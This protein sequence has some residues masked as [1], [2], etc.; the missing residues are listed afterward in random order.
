MP[1]SL[2][3][4]KVYEVL[5]SD[6]QTYDVA[7]SFSGAQRMLVE[8]YVRACQAL[9]LSVF[10]DKDV[11]AQMWGRNF[12]YEF[13]KVYGQG[14]ARYV[15]P[16]FSREYLGGSY[17]MDEYGAAVTWSIEQRDDV[18]I[19][20]I[21]IGDVRVPEELLNS[22]TAFLRAEEWTAAELAKITAERVR[23]SSA[24]ASL[25]SPAATSPGVLLPKIAPGGYSSYETLENALSLVAKRFQ[26][27][28][29]LLARYGYT[30][31]VRTPDSAVDVRVEAQGKPV[32][33]VKVWL[34]DSFGQDR[35]AVGLG[36]PSYRG[37]AMNGW[38][39]AE[40]D[41]EHDEARLRFA[42]GLQGMGAPLLTAD[43]FFE[44][45]WRKIVVR[46][47]QMH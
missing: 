1:R 40:W 22:S 25:P 21:V 34:D 13:R 31:R 8:N 16:F 39:T 37:S 28:A 24:G 18:Y 42:D 45:L 5:M 46:I 33:G 27:N 38:A 36:A 3:T 10:Y 29:P 30:C 15:V 35:L 4:R 2:F 6:R 43:E 23:S 9:G 14:N 47:E 44:A 26:S 7:V 11:A 20:P 12:I 41:K 17:P 19:L 32:Y